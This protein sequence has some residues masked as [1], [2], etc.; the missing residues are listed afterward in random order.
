VINSPA[1]PHRLRSLLS[2]AFAVL[3]GTL[4]ACSRASAPLNPADFSGP[5]KVACVGDSITYGY[6]DSPGHSYP[7]QLQA[8]LGSKWEIK[9]YGVN[10]RTL[11]RKGD[12]PWWKEQAFK[13]AHSLNP[14]VVV[15]MLGTN[16]TKPRNWV[17]EGEFYGDYK[18]LIESFKAL[19]SKPRIWI[20]RPCPVPAPGNYGINEKNL[21]VLLPLIDKLAA[22]EN[23]G[24][25]DIYGALKDHPE[26]FPDHVHPNDAGA[27]LM[28][29]T[30]AH[31][32]AK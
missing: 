30:V 21:D 2:I 16:D 17:H 10:G 9:N 14:D 24:E 6:G 8:L 20:M 18:D 32:L 5:I 28:A 4:V 23:V 26:L 29:Q 7:D 25:I 3:A 12:A 31:A 13:D 1:A 27:A 22:E 19:P 15:I 11:L